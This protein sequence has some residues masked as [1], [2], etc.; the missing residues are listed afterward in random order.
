[1]KQIYRSMRAILMLSLLFF[2]ALVGK[3]QGLTTVTQ[4]SFSAVTGN[5]DGDNNVT[6][7]AE[8]GGGTSNPV[9]NQ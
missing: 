1:M 9:V 6:Y 2:C 3:A 5:V 8:K 4:T 7:T